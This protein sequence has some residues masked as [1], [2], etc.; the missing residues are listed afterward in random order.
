VLDGV[1]VW[2]AYRPV[3]GEGMTV[4]TTTDRD[5]GFMFSLPDGPLERAVVGAHLE[6]IEPV[7]LEPGGRPLEPGDVVLIVSDIVP[8]HLRFGSA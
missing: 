1:T 5:G 2:F 3:D 6:G 4:E 8:S 7:D